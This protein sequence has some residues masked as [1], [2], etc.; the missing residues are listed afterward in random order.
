VGKLIQRIQEKMGDK[1]RV[2][3]CSQEGSGYC[4]AATGQWLCDPEYVQ[5]NITNEGFLEM[6]RRIQGEYETEYKKSQILLSP[7]FLIKKFPEL[8]DKLLKNEYVLEPKRLF[9]EI[10]FPGSTPLKRGRLAIL[11]RHNS[12]EEAHCLGVR[13]DDEIFKFFDVNECFCTMNRE[14]FEDFIN[15]YVT[16]EYGLLNKG[17]YTCFQ[18]I[19]FN[20]ELYTPA[21]LESLRNR[22]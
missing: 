10:I 21:E 12:G 11:L 22:R 19:L 8:T 3:E 4:L 9:E 2:K 5:A 20:C 18:V 14:I 16:D 1:I 17:G 13:I 6:L 7:T 15:Y